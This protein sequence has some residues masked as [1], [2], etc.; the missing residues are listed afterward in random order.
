VIGQRASQDEERGQDGEIAADDVRLP[1]E[2]TD[3][4]GG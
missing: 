1:L 3:E 4:R 2:D